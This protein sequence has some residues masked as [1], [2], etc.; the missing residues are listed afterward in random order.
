M[1]KFRRY[2]GAALDGHSST[3][4]RCQRPLLDDEEAQVAVK[5]VP[6]TQHVPHT[7]LP[8]TEPLHQSV[9]SHAARIADLYQA[10]D[11]LRQDMQE[12]LKLPHLILQQEVETQKRELPVPCCAPV[13]SIGATCNGRRREV[14]PGTSRLAPMASIGATCNGRRREVWPG[15][16]RLAP[17]ASIGATYNGRRRE[18]WR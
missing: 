10:L 15:T 5:E 7:P 13:A 8:D 14:W 2:C 12:Q 6:A 16:S 9:A 18:V 1:I 4:P 17:M 3:C 11:R